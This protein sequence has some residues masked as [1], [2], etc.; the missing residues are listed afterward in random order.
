MCDTTYLQLTRERIDSLSGV[1]HT[2]AQARAAHA[3]RA[4]LMEQRMREHE[5]S[6]RTRLDELAVASKRG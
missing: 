6:T 4:D 5:D 2:L 1:L 3:E